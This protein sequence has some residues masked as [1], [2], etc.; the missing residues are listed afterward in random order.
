MNYHTDK[1]LQLFMLVSIFLFET[2]FSVST[3]VN[4]QVNDINLVPKMGQIIKVQRPVSSVPISGLYHRSPGHL[5]G[6][7]I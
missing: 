1:Q 2:I 4:D 7:I 6:K 5:N 3:Q